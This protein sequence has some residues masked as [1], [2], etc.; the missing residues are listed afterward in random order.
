LEESRWK[1]AG[2]NRSKLKQRRKDESDESFSR[3]LRVRKRSYDHNKKESALRARFQKIGNL[4]CWTSST[5]ASEQL[6]PLLLENADA[7]TRQSLPS[8]SSNPISGS[9]YRRRSIAG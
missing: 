9:V 3:S 1:R 4:P 2:C 5:S 7:Q 8:S 6:S